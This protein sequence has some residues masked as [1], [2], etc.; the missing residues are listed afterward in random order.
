PRAHARLLAEPVLPVD[1]PGRPGPF[2]ARREARRRASRRRVRRRPVAPSQPAA[3]NR[4]RDG[5]RAHPRPAHLDL[6]PDSGGGGRGRPAAGGGRAARRGRIW[7]RMA[8][9]R[10]VLLAASFLTIG[11]AAGSAGGATRTYSTGPLAYA[12]PDVGT[13]EVPLRV[14]DAG[15]VSY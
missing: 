9:R 11:L 2:R 13:V 15:P 8:R 12:L 10:R 3:A 1:T 5:A 6:R 14:P 4:P 7:A